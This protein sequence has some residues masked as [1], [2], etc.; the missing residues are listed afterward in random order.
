[1][2]L[3]ST[4]LCPRGVPRRPGCSA[5]AMP[6]PRCIRRWSRFFRHGAGPPR[7]PGPWAAAGAAGSRPRCS[8][9]FG[10]TR[11]SRMTAMISSSPRAQFGPCC[12]SMS[13]TRPSRRG[14]PMAHGSRCA[15]TPASCPS[16]ATAVAGIRSRA[17]HGADIP[18]ASAHGP[19]CTELGRT[20]PEPPRPQKRGNVAS[21]TRP[22]AAS[23][24][25]CSRTSQPRSLPGLSSPAGSKR[26]LVATT[27]GLTWPCLPSSTM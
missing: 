27:S 9:V 21:E 22:A 25:I 2:T 18:G 14:H 24:M 19:R 7:T 5:A 1:M 17:P 13:N 15:G 26:I 23:A 8:R 12:M 20:A 10:I 6:V 11:R 16:P 4:A 3:P